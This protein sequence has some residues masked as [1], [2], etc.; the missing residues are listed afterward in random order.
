MLV[1][2]VAHPQ[3][4]PI[5][6]QWCDMKRYAKENNRGQQA[7]DFSLKKITDLL[8]FRQRMQGEASWLASWKH[9]WKF[10]TKQWEADETLLSEDEEGEE[11]NDE[12]DEENS[13]NENE[14]EME[15]DG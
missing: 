8:H 4:N 1:L 2:P 7:S 13:T 10:A 11:E 14:C 12:Q 15:I 6:L 9:T 3:L 5:E